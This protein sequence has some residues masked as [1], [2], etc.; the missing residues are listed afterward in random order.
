MEGV[1]GYSAHRN[2]L[3]PTAISLYETGQID[4]ICLDMSEAFHCVSHVRLII[5]LNFK[6]SK[7]WDG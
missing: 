6:I 1:D 3:R 2:S 5:K 7:L 4:A